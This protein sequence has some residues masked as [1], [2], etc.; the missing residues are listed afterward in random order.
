MQL[1]ES[2][3]FL[4]TTRVDVQTTEDSWATPPPALVYQ[5]DCVSETPAAV[6]TRHGEA[7]V[8]A[9]WGVLSWGVGAS[10]LHQSARDSPFCSVYTRAVVA[11]SV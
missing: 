9:L 5:S 10:C 4:T 11:C 1:L 6:S 2:F 3:P 8:R 7:V